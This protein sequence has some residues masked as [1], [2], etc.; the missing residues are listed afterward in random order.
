[1]RPPPAGSRYFFHSL[2]P[3]SQ[4]FF[5]GFLPPKEPFWSKLEHQV[6]LGMLL[7]SAFAGPSLRLLLALLKVVTEGRSRSVV[8][9]LRTKVVAR[10]CFR[11]VFG[12]EVRAVRTVGTLQN[13]VPLGV[14]VFRGASV[15]A[16][17]AVLSGST[18]NI[19]CSQVQ[20]ALAFDGSSRTGEAPVDL[21]RLRCGWLSVG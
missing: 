5:S 14:P 6:F 21:G 16:F 8:R 19:C 13:F 9:N 12:P 1:M 7:L 11:V 20:W 15:C 17:Y 10:V 18:G 3:A 4:P 2:Q